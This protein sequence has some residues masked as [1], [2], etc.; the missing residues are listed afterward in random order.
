MC[1]LLNLTNL[2]GVHTAQDILRHRTTSSDVVRSVNTAVDRVQLFL[3]YI[4]LKLII[5]I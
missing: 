2:S 5:L 4:V 3:L 1:L